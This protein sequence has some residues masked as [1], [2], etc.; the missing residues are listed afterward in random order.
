MAMV[1]ELTWTA[2]TKPD[3]GLLCGG[4]ALLAVG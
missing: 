4:L 3:G 1:W 2:V